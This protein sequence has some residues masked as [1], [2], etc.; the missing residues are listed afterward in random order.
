MT[1]TTRAADKKVEVV[2]TTMMEAADNTVEDATTTAAA[3][4]RMTAMVGATR[5]V[6]HMVEVML[7]TTNASE[8]ATRAP[9]ADST[10]ATTMTTK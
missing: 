8:A 5:V 7:A 4:V 9:E 10:A 6:P 2:E 1:T 3:V